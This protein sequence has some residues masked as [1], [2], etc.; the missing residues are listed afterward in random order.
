MLSGQPSWSLPAS[1]GG[2][3]AWSEPV[4]P[5]VS[6]WGAAELPPAV[7]AQAPLS[8]GPSALPGSAS[9]LAPVP[10]SPAMPAPHLPPHTGELMA[11]SWVK[12][13]QTCL[14]CI[15]AGDGCCAGMQGAH[16]HA[17]A[18]AAQGGMQRTLFPLK[19]RPTSLRMH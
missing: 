13:Q 8:G 14:S 11:T 17:H 1:S 3:A 2:P 4:W 6:G 15:T 18:F 7:A 16:V 19:A 10:T 12:G 9:W 5:A